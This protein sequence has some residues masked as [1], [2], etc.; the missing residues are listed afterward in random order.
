MSKMSVAKP[1]MAKKA[2][3]VPRFTAVTLKCLDPKRVTEGYRPPLTFHEKIIDNAESLLKRTAKDVTDIGFFATMRNSHDDPHNVDYI[4]LYLHAIANTL[5]AW[6]TVSDELIAEW[7]AKEG[8][9]WGEGPTAKMADIGRRITLQVDCLS[10]IRAVI[11]PNY[12]KPEAS[13]LVEIASLTDDCV[14]ACKYT[15]TI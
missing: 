14:K 11:G 12:P 3:R 4:K 9:V 10:A 13:L 2:R 7:K 5:T 1:T 6:E 15:A 8:Q